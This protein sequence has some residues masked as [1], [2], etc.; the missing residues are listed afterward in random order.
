MRN[1]AIAD[2]LLDGTAL[3]AAHRTGLSTVLVGEDE[4][5]TAAISH[6]RV[7]DYTITLLPAG[8][9]PPRPGELWATD[10]ATQ[11][12]EYVGRAFD[13]VIVDTPPLGDCTDGAI[14]GA[15]GDG[16]ILLARVGGTTARSLR[17]AVQILQ[18]AHVALL[19]TVVTFEAVSRGAM[20]AHAKQRGRTTVEN[21]ESETKVQGRTAVG[22]R[23]SET[24]V[25]GRTA[26]GARESETPVD[27]Q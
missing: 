18:S 6:V 8:P 25:Q 27:S 1:P 16:A 17:R 26:V 4:I 24:K 20:R 12:L 5:G 19:G 7:G 10:R 15:L 13:Y 11:L 9:L 22:A 21:R 23:E 2:R 3:L 14:V